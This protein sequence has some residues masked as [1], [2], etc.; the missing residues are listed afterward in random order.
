MRAERDGNF[1]PRDISNRFHRSEE[2]VMTSRLLRRLVAAAPQAV[3]LEFGRNRRTLD[4]SAV[5]A[6]EQY[7]ATLRKPLCISDTRSIVAS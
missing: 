7:L 1:M 3:P 5:D 2:N 6:L 4:V